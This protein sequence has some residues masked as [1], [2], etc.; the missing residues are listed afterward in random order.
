MFHVSFGWQVAW[1]AAVV[2]GLLSVLLRTLPWRRA[3]WL[4]L[5]V[6]EIA[7][8]LALYGAWCFVG[9]WTLR[10]TSGAVRRG[11]D[12]W[13]AERQLH[14]LSEAAV[15]YPL[16]PH[17]WLVHAAD[18]YYIYGHFNMLI[19]AV[20]WTWLRHRD[21]YAELR[22]AV[23]LFSL[24]ATLVQIVPVAPPR[25][26]PGHLVVDTALRYGESVYGPGGIGAPSQLAAVP[27]VHVGWS[28]LV[29]LTVVRRSTSRWRCLAPLHPALMGVVVVA[30]GNHYWADGAVSVLLLGLTWAVLRVADAAAVRR[31]RAPIPRVLAGPPLDSPT[32][33]SLD[34]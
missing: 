2:V 25:L 17:P 14:L 34:A 4:G 22:R 7:V 10:D 27:S 33:T 12:I 19:A 26:L 11:E 1:T 15:Q 20:A 8:M 29:A 18:T 32:P 28:I 13:A 30:T 16:L 21:A 3:R 6:R 31:R 23:I 9:A 24:S 5:G